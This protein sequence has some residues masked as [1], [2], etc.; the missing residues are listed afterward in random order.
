[1]NWEI[2]FAVLLLL[3]GLG[4]AIGLRKRF[5]RKLSL[6]EKSAASRLGRGP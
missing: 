2:V 5:K 1:M 4:E 6:A 3:V